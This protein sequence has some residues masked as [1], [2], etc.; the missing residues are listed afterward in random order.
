MEPASVG[1]Q[2]TF[3][4]KDQTVNI[5]GFVGPME[6]ATTIQ[7]CCSSM[8]AATDNDTAVNEYSCVPIKL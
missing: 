1:G 5:F 6:F 8:K 2:P 7:F 4:L 3:Y